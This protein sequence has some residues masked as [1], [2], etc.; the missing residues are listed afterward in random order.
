MTNINTILWA[1]LMLAGISPAAAAEPDDTL[2][3]DNAQLVFPEEYQRQRLIDDAKVIFTGDHSERPPVD[4]VNSLMMR[5]Y[6]DQFR[7]FQ[8]PKL[9]YFI[10]S[11]PR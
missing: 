7:H 3:L 10:P 4:S 2:Y 11:A 1:L 6:L 5:Y 9:P 8:D